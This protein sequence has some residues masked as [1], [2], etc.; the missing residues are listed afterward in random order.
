MRWLRQELNGVVTNEWIATNTPKT[1][2]SFLLSRHIIV[3]VRLFDKCLFNTFAK[4]D[5][6]SY[7]CGL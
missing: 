5:F 3:L 7:F 2:I 1:Y 4:N 6:G